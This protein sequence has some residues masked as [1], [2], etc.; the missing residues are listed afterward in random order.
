MEY[1]CVHEY[2]MPLL[3]INKDL[4]LLTTVLKWIIPYAVWTFPKRSISHIVQK[5]FQWNNSYVIQTVL[6]L[7]KKNPDVCAKT[8]S[9]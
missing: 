3:E 7:K 1:F 6:S 9:K 8:F 5:H 2:I 4:G